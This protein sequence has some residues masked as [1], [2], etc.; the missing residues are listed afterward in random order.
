MLIFFIRSRVV[1]V[2][3]ATELLLLL[4]FVEKKALLGTIVDNGILQFIC[5]YC[6]L[7]ADSEVFF[8]DSENSKF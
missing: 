4:S 7:A 5:I 8:N 6:V 1:E 3:L 2:F